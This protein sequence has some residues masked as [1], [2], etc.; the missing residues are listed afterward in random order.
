MP[1]HYIGLDLATLAGVAILYPGNFAAVTVMKGNPIQQ[2]MHV[3]SIVNGLKVPELS[4]VLEMPVDFLNANT[5][6]S[7]LERYGFIK[8]NLIGSG[9][10]PLEVRPKEAR[11]VVGAKDK[12]SLFIKLKDNFKGHIFDSNMSDALALCIYA[13]A[14]DGYKVDWKQLEIHNL[15]VE[16]PT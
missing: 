6:R 8:W 15:K 7:L 3:G 13:A 4:I 16:E 2:F 14:Q 5:T 1:K 12:R 11:R 9:F 10:T